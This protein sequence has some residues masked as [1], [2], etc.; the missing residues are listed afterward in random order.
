MH[1]LCWDE[2]RGESSAE[3]KRETE[4]KEN[5][6]RSGEWRQT[7]GERKEGEMIGERREERGEGNNYR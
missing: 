7:E 2:R 4:A 3:I 5:K 1:T 6:R